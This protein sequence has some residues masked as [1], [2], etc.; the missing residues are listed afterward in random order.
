M[1]FAVWHFKKK[2][3]KLLALQMA[4]QVLP[5][6]DGIPS[7]SSSSSSSSEVLGV[8]APRGFIPPLE[9]SCVELPAA[10]DLKAR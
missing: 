7:S 6:K 8:V 2:A 10:G 9:G 3:N 1:W 5:R 4:E